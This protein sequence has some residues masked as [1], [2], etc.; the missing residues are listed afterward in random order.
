MTA[1]SRPW[2]SAGFG[3]RDAL[4]GLAAAVLTPALPASAQHKPSPLGPGVEPI[5]IDAGPIAAFDRADSSR[6]RFGKLDFIGGLVLSSPSAGFGGWSGLAVEADGSR[7]L[8]VSDAGSW[9]TADLVTQNG[10][11][12]G[13]ANARR[14]PIVALRGARLSRERDRDAEAVALAEGTLANGVV[15]I[16]FERNRR[17]GRFPFGERG[18]GAPTG[19]LKLPADAARMSSNKAFEAV[20]RSSPSPSA[21][22]TSRATTPAGSGSIGS[23]N[24]LTC[25]TSASTISPMP[26]RYPMADCCCSSGAFAG[27]RG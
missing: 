26:Q 11:P 19:Y 1:K 15:L 27:S 20:A 13:L 22:S 24:V 18:L 25:A 23:R 8:A 5:D 9:M 2:R 14:G 12:K 3:R 4:A 6:R 10:V 21:I 17:I 16:A 7:L